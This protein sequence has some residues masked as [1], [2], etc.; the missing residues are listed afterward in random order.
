MSWFKM[1]GFSAPSSEQRHAQSS[2]ECVNEPCVEAVG[3]ITIF[4]PYPT[5]GDYGLMLSMLLI[6][7]ELIQDPE[8]LNHARATQ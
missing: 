5:A 1:Q 8:E 2:P 6:Q 7:F 4:K 3:I